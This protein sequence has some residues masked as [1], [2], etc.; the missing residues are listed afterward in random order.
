MGVAVDWL[1]FFGTAD[2]VTA[3]VVSSFALFQV[4][5][6][7]YRRTLGS[8]WATAKAIRSLTPGN[9]VEWVERYFG[10]HLY[11][12]SYR[13]PSPQ[14]DPNGEEYLVEQ[15]L[16]NARH[17]W[18]TVHYNEGKVCAF[19]FMITDPKFRFSVD[20][21]CRGVLSGALGRS[22]FAEMSSEKPSALDMFVGA[23]NWGYSETHYRGRPGN[24]QYY[25]FSRT[26]F[27]WTAKPGVS[28][29]IRS[30]TAGDDAPFGSL[31][32]SDKALIFTYR[33]EVAPDTVGVFG[34]GYRFSG[35]VSS[36][37]AYDQDSLRN[38]EG[39]GPLGWSS[40]SDFARRE[41]RRVRL[42][43]LQFWRIGV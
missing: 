34:L 11:A 6:G 33:K 16:Y 37:G 10:G 17:G 24:Y 20:A 36:S 27:G 8:R 35:A 3:V 22:T 38:L 13:Q 14:Y 31:P 43:R 40:R 29:E 19:A 1:Q 32:E 2:N 21:T 23:Y 41:V 15:R 28:A 12:T 39:E 26:M 7:V 42:R 4:A 5:R 30:V 9:P 18:L 25:S